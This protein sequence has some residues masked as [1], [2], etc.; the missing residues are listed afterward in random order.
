MKDVKFEQLKAMLDY[1]YRGE[2]KISQDQLGTFLKA[3]ESLQIKGLSDGTS[4]YES[5]PKHKSTSDSKTLRPSSKTDEDRTSIN[6]SPTHRQKKRRHPS[7]SFDGPVSEENSNDQL[8]ESSTPPPSKLSVESRLSNPPTPPCVPQDSDSGGPDE[9]TRI[10]PFRALPVPTSVMYSKSDPPQQQPSSIMDSLVFEPKS[11]FI[12]LDDEEDLN[13]DDDAVEA[14]PSH[15][16]DNI[17]GRYW[18][19][20]YNDLHY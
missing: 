18:R 4:K 1:M 12:E 20:I 10:D 15:S 14:G 19:S 13:Q 17:G 11:E 6:I 7:G 5:Q 9:G 16:Q 3:A 2:V 8:C